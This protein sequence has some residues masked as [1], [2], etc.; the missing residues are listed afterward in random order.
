MRRG[1]AAL[2]EAESPASG[3]EQ[4]DSPDSA[5]KTRKLML[6]EMVRFLSVVVWRKIIRHTIKAIQSG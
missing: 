3:I 4:T 6:A 5:P 1:Q 2:A